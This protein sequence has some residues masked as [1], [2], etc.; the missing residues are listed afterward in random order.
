[1][2]YWETICIQKPWDA[3]ISRS[4]FA[5]LI[6]ISC[7][8]RFRCKMANN[9]SQGNL[10]IRF[11]IEK[12]QNGAIVSKYV[13]AIEVKIHPMQSAVQPCWFGLKKFRNC[14]NC[15]QNVNNATSFFLFL[16]FYSLHN[17]NLW[18]LKTDENSNNV[19]WVFWF[20]FGIWG[21]LSPHPLNAGPDQ[22]ESNLHPRFL[23]HG[24]HVWGIAP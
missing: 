4:E 18:Q 11:D 16:L 21:I 9:G 3:F 2:S 14:L 13:R 23:V 24:P 5:K 19:N 15:Y 17:Y 20:L 8:P 1:M 22:I 6:T 10:G 7:K 12:L